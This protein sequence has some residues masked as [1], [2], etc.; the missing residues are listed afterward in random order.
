MVSVEEKRADFPGIDWATHCFRC[1]T[2]EK[3]YA[4]HWSYISDTDPLGREV[5]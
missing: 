1:Y 5:P 3:R 2:L 4:H